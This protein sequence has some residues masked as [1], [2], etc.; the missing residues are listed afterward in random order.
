MRDAEMMLRYW[1]KLRRELSDQQRAGLSALDVISRFRVDVMKRG[2]RPVAVEIPARMVDLT[3]PGT[4]IVG[5]N[6]KW[7]DYEAP[8]AILAHRPG[9]IGRYEVRIPERFEHPLTPPPNNTTK[10]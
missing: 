10:P 4:S 7:V 2:F 8:L 1:Q 6:V 3:M 9:K 5:L